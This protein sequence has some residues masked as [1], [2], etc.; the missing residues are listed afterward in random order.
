MNAEK[1][2][3]LSKFIVPE[4]RYHATFLEGSC[5]EDCLSIKI[6]G[7]Q[8]MVCIVKNDNTY[9]TRVI[10]P[11]SDTF[12]QPQ[13]D[14]LI[15]SSADD[16]VAFI[17][18]WGSRLERVVNRY[19]KLRSNAGIIQAAI[20]EIRNNH[21]PQGWSIDVIEPEFIEQFYRITITMPENQEVILSYISETTQPYFMA[22]FMAFPRKHIHPRGNISPL[23]LERLT[24]L[25]QQI[26]EE[27]MHRMPTT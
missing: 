25:I 2:A 6:Q 14:T 12:T 20:L 5:H 7:Q 18:T 3:L 11:D 13:W 15:T 16:T 22:E 4:L 10:R 9:Q 21:L 17:N 27:F 23:D 26:R 19:F 1:R 8:V 24:E